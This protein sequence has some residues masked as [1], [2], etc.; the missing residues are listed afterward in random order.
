[1]SKPKCKII[2]E[3]LKSQHFYNGSGNNTEALLSKGFSKAWSNAGSSALY[4]IEPGMSRRSSE[5]WTIPQSPA[6][7]PEEI[8]DQLPSWLAGC[9]KGSSAGCLKNII[10][11]PHMVG[12][13]AFAAASSLMANGVTG[14]DAG[15]AVYAELACVKAMAELF[16]WRSNDA[17]GCFTFGGTGT[18]L[19]GIRVGLSKADPE[20]SAVGLSKKC[21]VLSSLASHYSHMTACQWLGLG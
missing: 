13:S 14:E 4:P 19:Y 5:S 21:Y 18:I 11:A 8:L 15:N 17:A 3:M 2:L 10:P 12:I 7:D 1:M 6:V 16:G 20:A 9:V